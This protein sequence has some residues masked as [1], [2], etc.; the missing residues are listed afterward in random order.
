MRPPDDR[1]LCPAAASETGPDRWQE[2][3]DE[4]TAFYRVHIGPLRGTLFALGATPKLVD[5]VV[6]ESFLALRRA[7]PKV[8]DYEKP[9]A[10][11]YKVATHRLK[12]AIKDEWR[13]VELDKEL[14]ER[15]SPPADPGLSL[16]V[17][18]ALGELA[19]R[20]LEVVV[21]RWLLQFSGRQTAKILDIREGT[22]KRYLY[23]GGQKLRELLASPTDRAE[24]Q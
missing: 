2:F 18:M 12:D 4:V 5:D 9:E 3:N 7:W 19:P 15:S 24:G 21:Y 23:E 22:V 11:L 17:V 10:Y 1:D 14:L 13:W 8:R 16:E 20:Q 6:Q